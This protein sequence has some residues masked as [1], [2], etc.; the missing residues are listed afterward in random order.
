M[1]GLPQII[2]CE[3]SGSMRSAANAS[4]R[5]SSIAAGM[6]EHS[7]LAQTSRLTIGR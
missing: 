7:A 3:C 1:S 2:T 4:S 5:P 6:R